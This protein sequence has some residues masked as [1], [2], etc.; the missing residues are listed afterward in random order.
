MSN[1][2]IRL[3]KSFIDGAIAHILHYATM[4]FLIWIGLYMADIQKYS[5]V[6]ILGFVVVAR[7]CRV[8]ITAPWNH[9]IKHE[10][11]EKLPA[12]EPD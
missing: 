3:L 6:N 1:L 4:A 5:F 12:G 11:R 7:Q 10:Q 2:T 9:H 8:I